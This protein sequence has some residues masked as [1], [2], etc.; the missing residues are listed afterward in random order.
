MAHIVR[1]VNP[2]GDVAYRVRWRQ[3]GSYESET[4]AKEGDAKKF[5]GLVDAAGQRYPEGWVK[6]R[7]I[8]GLVKSTAPTLQEWAERAIASRS[9][10]NER[11]R[12]AYL[13]MVTTH[14]PAEMLRTRIDEITREQVGAWVILMSSKQEPK[15]VRNVHGMLSSVMNDAVG[16][17]LIGR[18]PM[19]GASA[20]LPDTRTKEP[21]FL[22]P[23]EFAALLKCVHPHF[24]NFVDHFARTGVRFGE[25]VA[26]EPEQVDLAGKTER[27]DRS[28]KRD[29]E[30][31]FYVGSPKSRKSTRTLAIDDNTVDLLA[32]EIADRASGP[33]FL[34]LEGSRIRSSH[35]WDRVWGPAVDKAFSE[36]GKRPRI[37]DLRHSHASW[38]I[39]A[40]VSLPAIQARLGHESIT[41]TI[42]R[43]G[44]LMPEAD[45]EAS[46][47]LAQLLA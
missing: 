7:G 24:R 9:R 3:D 30:G 13:K 17:G 37:H 44:H 43:Y 6:G 31:Q 33:V 46:A 42:D 23:D 36:I 25:A 11:T 19:K 38:L 26:L 10:A 15:T 22:T 20:P 14:V 12:A 34:S 16:A 32:V 2:S 39:A 28:L 27:I 4:F 18:N 21:V 40:G 35:F 5:R 29:A 1:R 45:R 8:A 47:A 41:T